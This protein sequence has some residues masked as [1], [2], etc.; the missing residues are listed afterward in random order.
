M[1]NHITVSSIIFGVFIYAVD[2]TVHV[3]ELVIILVLLNQLDILT[4]DITRRRGLWDG[5]VG[6]RTVF[7]PTRPQDA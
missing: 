3:L 1:S 5:T 2:S 7:I 6:S 4:D